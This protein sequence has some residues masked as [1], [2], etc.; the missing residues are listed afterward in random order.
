[1]NLQYIKSTAELL[2]GRSWNWIEKFW[3]DIQKVIDNLKGEK[4]FTS[5][6]SVIYNDEKCHI[7]NNETVHSLSSKMN[8]FIFKNQI[9]E[10]E[11]NWEN[12]RIK[13]V[14][15]LPKLKNLETTH[16]PKYRYK[17]HRRRKVKYRRGKV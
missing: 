12:N 17:S 1:M 14:F 7:W 8:V 2:S 9:R 10:L 11:T 6:P 16:K 15:F 4:A 13:R 5:R 3:S